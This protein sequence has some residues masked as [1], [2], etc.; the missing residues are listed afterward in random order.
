[1]KQEKGGRDFRR[2]LAAERLSPKDEITLKQS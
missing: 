2:R 1:M